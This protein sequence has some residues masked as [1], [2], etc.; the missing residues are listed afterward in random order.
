M[1]LALLILMAVVATPQPA[2]AGLTKPDLEAVNSIDYGQVYVVEQS[3]RP[4]PPWRFGVNYGYEFG[5]SYLDVFTTTLVIERALRRYTWIGIQANLFSSSPSPLMKALTRELS[6]TT[7]LQA[8]IYSIYS[9]F[10][11]MPFHGHMSFLGTRPLEAELSIRVGTGYLSYP[12]SYRRFGVLWAL[13]P[14]VHF[15]QKWSIQGGLG[16][17][18]ESIFSGSDRL[19]HFRGELGLAFQI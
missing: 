3:T 18:I 7:Q 17:E 19:F 13:R 2:Q 5:N 9:I 15:S 6:F 11:W 12:T 14:S 8:P 16:Q 10:T 1:V 4:V